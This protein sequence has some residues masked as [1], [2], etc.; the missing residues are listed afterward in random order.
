MQ[1][2]TLVDNFSG[3]CIPLVMLTCSSLV[4][5]FHVTSL[6]SELLQLEGSLVVESLSSEESHTRG[7]TVSYC[8]LI[9]FSQWSKL[10]QI[11]ETIPEQIALCMTCCTVLHACMQWMFMC[12]RCH[13]NLLLLINIPRNIKE[14]RLESVPRSFVGSKKPRCEL[15][16][17]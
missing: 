11:R 9:L 12:G 14:G 8:S 6:I 10:E 2:E 4:A 15:R 17:H 1:S 5:T 3:V 13:R 16:V 7:N